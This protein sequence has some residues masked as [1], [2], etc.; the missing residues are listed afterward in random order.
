METQ[1]NLDDIGAIYTAED[2]REAA[3]KAKGIEGFYKDNQEVKY[4]LDSIKTAAEEGKTE[5]AVRFFS[6]M[7]KL[8]LDNCG[9]NIIT[10]RDFMHTIFW[11]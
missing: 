3:L 7:T 1:I 5:V 2:A 9:Y 11:E 6:K 8:I 10:G 4:V